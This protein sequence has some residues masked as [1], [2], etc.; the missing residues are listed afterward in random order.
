MKQRIEIEHPTPHRE[1]IAVH[2][3]SGHPVEI[4]VTPAGAVTQNGPYR[5]CKDCGRGSE[6]HLTHR[7][8]FC[9]IQTE[10]HVVAGC[11][12]PVGTTECVHWRGGTLCAHCL[13]H[14]EVEEVGPC[15]VCKR[16]ACQECTERCVEQQGEG[17]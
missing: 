10:V 5:L 1:V 13:H 3:G 16:P 11:L 9:G 2:N 8:S 4:G 7:C 6:S 15:V 14:F 17:P 12:V